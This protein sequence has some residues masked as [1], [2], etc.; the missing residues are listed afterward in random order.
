MSEPEL[1]ADYGAVIGEGPLWDPDRAVLYS[2]DIAEG[3]L[4]RYDPATQSGDRVF[5]GDRAIGGFTLQ[6][7]GALLLFEAGGAIERW[8]PTSGTT[9]T[10]RESL[11][12]E[13]DSRFNDVVADPEGRV[14][15]GTMPTAERL[16]RLYRVD[17][18]G[19]ITRIDEGFDIPNGMGF[20]RDLSTLYLAVSDDHV[21]YAY[22][23]HR[24]TGELTNRRVFVDTAGETGVPDGL[25]VD[26]DDH[27]WC[28]RWD[29]HCVVRYAPDGTEDRRIEVPPAK[30]SSLAFGGPDYGELYITT[31]RGPDGNAIDEAGGVYRVRPGVSGTAEYRS[32]VRHD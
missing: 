8:D 3:D 2:V 12:A 10:I 22:D 19:T 29:G 23:Y 25:T 7:D 28:A 31:A 20:S 18:D 5:D 14:Y 17:L 27:V 9:R 26:A 4:F 16:G 24:D 1:V 15:A 11:E 32:R 21:I 6:A 30:A 13:V